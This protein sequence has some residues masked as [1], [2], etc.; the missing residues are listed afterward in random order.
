MLNPT[1]NTSPKPH[2]QKVLPNEHPCHTWDL[3]G[4]GTPFEHAPMRLMNNKISQPQLL[5]KIQAQE[6]DPIRIDPGQEL[7]MSLARNHV[8]L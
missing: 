3:K 1:L 6:R 8:L 4:L 2:P 7:F 5:L